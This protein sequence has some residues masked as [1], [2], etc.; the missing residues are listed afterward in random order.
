MWLTPRA[1]APEG[2]TGFVARNG[3]RGAHC[4]GTLNDQVVAVSALSASPKSTP[5]PA[6]SSRTDSP[7]SP[8]SVPFS[9]S[10][11]IQS[12]RRAVNSRL[13]LLVASLAS[14]TATQGSAGASP[15]N[16]T[17]GKIA[18]ESFGTLDPALPSSRTLG[19]SSPPLP[20][21]RM[22]SLSGDFFSIA[23]CQTWPRFGTLAN[24][25]LYRQPTLARRTGEIASGSSALT[26]TPTEAD[27]PTPAVFDTTGG[28]Y[29]TEL[30]ESGFRSFHNGIPHG[31]KLA[32]AV[33]VEPT[34][35]WLMPSANEDAAGT[36]SGKMQRMLSHQAREIYEASLSGPPRTDSGLPVPASDSTGGSR[37]ESWAT[38]TG[39]DAN[40]ATRASGDFQS[41]TRQVGKLNPSWVE[42][43]MGLPMGH[44]QLPY[45][46][47][48][49]K[50]GTP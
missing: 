8:T 4:F 30:T 40:N 21:P 1:N 19:D 38:P 43:L 37:R 25:T 36:T 12:L 41:L 3:D 44:T 49:P 7:M 42:T 11:E 18:G 34:R 32:D 31:T 2:D 16:A 35:D 23:F 15:T 14:R 9:Q 22:V 10:P 48:K 5:T 17:S 13:S 6:P 29:P 28:P 46:F 50:R 20:L 33:R 45:K 39:D 27:W 47:V 24:G 26:R